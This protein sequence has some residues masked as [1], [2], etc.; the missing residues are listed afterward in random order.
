MNTLEWHS[1][2]YKYFLNVNLLSDKTQ[3]Y[4]KNT[5][6][7]TSYIYGTMILLSVSL[8]LDLSHVHST[9]SVVFH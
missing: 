9:Y 7:N 1:V 4:H 2:T 6:N 3:S 8:K 5:D